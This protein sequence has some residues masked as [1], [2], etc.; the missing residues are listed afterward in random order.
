MRNRKPQ[1]ANCALQ[2]YVAQIKILARRSLFSRG[3]EWFPEKRGSLK[4]LAW[5]WNL[6]KSFWWVSKSRFQVILRLGVSNFETGSRSL[7]FTIL[8]P[9]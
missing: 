5:S 4:I 1:T 7:A 3:I 6:G 2:F 8:Y 9:F